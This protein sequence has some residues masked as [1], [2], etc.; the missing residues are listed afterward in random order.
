MRAIPSAGKVNVWACAVLQVY[1]PGI[2][3]TG[4]F[5]SI[6]NQAVMMNARNMLFASLV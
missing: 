1:L 2:I 5:F 3:V 4:I 6:T